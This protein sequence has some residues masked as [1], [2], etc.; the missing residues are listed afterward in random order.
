MYSRFQLAAKY[1]KYYFTSSNGKGHGTHSPFIFHFIT[2]I[3][4]D[5]KDYGEYAIVEKLRSQLVQDYSMLEIEDFGAGSTVNKTNRRTISSIAKNSAKPEKYGQLLF[6]MVKEYKPKQILELGTSLGITTSYL[7]LGNTA[8]IVI[9][10]E[11][12]EKVAEV[13]HKNFEGL[14]LQN[15]SIRTGNFDHTLPDVIN[16]QPPYDF[17][18]V[19]GN[20][21][22]EPTERYFTE[23]LTRINNNSIMIFDDIHWSKEMEMA[24]DSIKSHTEVRCTIDLFFIGIVLFRKEFLDKEHFVIRF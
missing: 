12:S 15:I 2:S 5:R 23:L 1:L 19:D 9:T 6:R 17:I 4:N 16:N 21:R 11:G 18:F 13:A 24:W 20:H 3:L 7:A 10:M 14:E 22:Q 8:A